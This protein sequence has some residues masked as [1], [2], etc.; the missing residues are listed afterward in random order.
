MVNSDAELLRIAD[1]VIVNLHA[2]CCHEGQANQKMCH[3]MIDDD[4]QPVKKPHHVDGSA[5]CSD[6]VP[7]PGIVLPRFLVRQSNVLRQ[8]ERGFPRTRTRGCCP[9]WRLTRFA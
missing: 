3:R 4:F 7:R 9:G 1:Q 8:R 5:T 6:H 2:A